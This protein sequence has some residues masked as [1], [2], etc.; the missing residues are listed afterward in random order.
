MNTTELNDTIADLEDTT[1][2]LQ[3]HAAS[4]KSMVKG[5]PCNVDELKDLLTELADADDDCG[6]HFKR[7]QS[8]RNKEWDKQS[9]ECRDDWRRACRRREEAVSKAIKFAR[10]LRN[11]QA[12]A[13]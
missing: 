7:F 10:A 9:Q 1:R 8:E 4:M 12:E 6:D 2:K 3:R 5:L 13:A 11:G